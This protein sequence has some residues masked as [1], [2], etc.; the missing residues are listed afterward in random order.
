[1]CFRKPPEAVY[2]HNS[3]QAS[4]RVGIRL[5]PHEADSVAW[6]AGSIEVARWREPGSN[7]GLCG[8][9]RAKGKSARWKKRCRRA[10]AEAGRGR[11]LE[12]SRVPL[13]PGPAAISHSFAVRA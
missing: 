3:F 5:S 8:C 6:E 1:M 13:D 2:L 7:P 10:R 12:Y 11:L 9:M 4:S